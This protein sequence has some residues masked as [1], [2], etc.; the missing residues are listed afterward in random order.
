MTAVHH[1]YLAAF[2]AVLLGETPTERDRGRAVMDGCLPF[3]LA[4][5]KKED[6]LDRRIRRDSKNRGPL[7][8]PLTRLLHDVFREE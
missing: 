3:V 5:S 7:Q 6:L 1:R 8:K 2:D 4:Q